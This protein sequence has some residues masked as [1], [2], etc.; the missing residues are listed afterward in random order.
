MGR[1]YPIILIVDDSQA[2][3]EFAQLVIKDDLKFVT[4]ITASNGMEGLQMYKK[5]KPDVIILDWKMPVMDGM[6]VLK[7][8]MKDDPRTKVIMTTAYTEDQ[9]LLNEMKALGALCFVPKPTQRLLLLKAIN[10]G[11]RER[12]NA[13][14]YGQIPNV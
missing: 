3:R 1:Q 9:L 12:K 4:V 8:V 11:L 5:Y 10:D 2:F 13:G 7:A 6:Q 14:L